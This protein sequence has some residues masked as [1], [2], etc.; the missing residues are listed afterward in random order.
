[1]SSKPRT[2]SF[3]ALG[4]LLASVPLNADAQERDH[5]EME[6]TDGCLHVITY[7][8]EYDRTSWSV[9]CDDGFFM[10]GNLSGNSVAIMC[11]ASQEV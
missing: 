5:C 10:S 7:S 4:L 6:S 11:I 2:R 8:A 9:D 3:L 1:M